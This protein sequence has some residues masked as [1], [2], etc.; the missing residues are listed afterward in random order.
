[1]FYFLYNVTDT[2]DNFIGWRYVQVHN[3]VAN[4]PF[5]RYHYPL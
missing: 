5:E 4:S 1:M 2:F 3:A